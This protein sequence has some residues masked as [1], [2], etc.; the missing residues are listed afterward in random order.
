MSMMLFMDH[1]WQIL[2]I[3]NKCFGAAP[4]DGPA[5]DNMQQ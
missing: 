1:P 2:L 5:P 3:G 4:G